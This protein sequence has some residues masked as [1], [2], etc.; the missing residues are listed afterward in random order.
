MKIDN[1]LDFLQPIIADHNRSRHIRLVAIWATK[2]AT[3]AYPDKV[4]DDV[5][6]PDRADK[7]K[8]K[9]LTKSKLFFSIVSEIHLTCER[10]FK[11]ADVFWPI[12]TNRSEPL[13]IRTSALNMLMMSE[14]TV[15]R[16]LTLYWFMQA[17]PNQ[18]IYN[19]YYTTINS[20]ANSKYPCHNK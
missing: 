8:K 17:E 3:A 13:E 7:P 20:M 15:S 18:Q 10:T 11:V 16:F 12:L 2:S 4:T 5:I 9:T 1:I 14:P 6:L 19:F